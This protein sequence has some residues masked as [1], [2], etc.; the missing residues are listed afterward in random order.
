MNQPNYFL[1]DLPPEA[2]LSPAMIAEACQTLKRNRGRY[3]ASRS[4]DGLVKVLSEVAAN[5]LKTDNPFRKLA[6]E[7]G[8]AKTGFSRETLA[9]GL[10]SFFRQLTPVIFTRCSF[11]NSAMRNGWMS[12]APTADTIVRARQ[13]QPGPELLVHITAGI[14][15]IQP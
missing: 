9:K 8:P 10:D 11:R 1:A 13:W 2:T 14:F 15:R 3:L 12:S 6:L 4:T 7:L 5:W